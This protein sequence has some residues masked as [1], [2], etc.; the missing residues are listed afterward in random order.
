MILPLS[1]AE[2]M[3]GWMDGGRDGP[4]LEWTNAS[5]IFDKDGKIVNGLQLDL[6]KQQSVWWN[7]SEFPLLMYARIIWDIVEKFAETVP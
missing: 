2:Q 3:D 7:F 1:V 5:N 6:V 4:I